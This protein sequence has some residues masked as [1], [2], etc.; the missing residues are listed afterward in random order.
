MG[1]RR[2]SEGGSTPQEGGFL[3]IGPPQLQPSPELSRAEKS[4]WLPQSKELRHPLSASL[5]DQIQNLRSASLEDNLNLILFGGASSISLPS[6][7]TLAKTS[8]QGADKDSSNNV[9]AALAIRS[10]V[11]TKG[12]LPLKEGLILPSNQALWNFYFGSCLKNKAVQGIRLET[13]GRLTKRFTA[14]RS[15]FK[16]K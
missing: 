1:E 12:V 3:Y 5:E 15:V 4:S 9:K 2:F 16:F 7:I 8:K 13:K 10:P 11:S 6:Q 14:S